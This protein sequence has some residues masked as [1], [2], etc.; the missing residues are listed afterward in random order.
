MRKCLKDMALSD[1]IGITGR[2]DRTKFRHQV[3]KPLLDASFVEMTVPDKPCSSN[4]KYRL[5]I[6]GQRRL[7]RKGGS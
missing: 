4:Q 5:A 7:D 3:L 6:F 1:L 2:N